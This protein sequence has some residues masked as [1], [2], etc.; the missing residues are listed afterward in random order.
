MIKGSC[1]CEGVAYE[2]TRFAKPPTHCHCKM[3]QKISGSA[4]GTYG[5]PEKGGFKFTRGDDL[6]RSYAATE[7]FVRS[8]CSVCG[9]TLLFAPKNGDHVAVALG[10]LDDEAG[11]APSKHIFIESKADWFDVVDDLPK[12]EGYGD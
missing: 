12:V 2:I 9:S 7:E 1:L 6:V 10:T 3:C 4:F 5:T 11:I 8:F